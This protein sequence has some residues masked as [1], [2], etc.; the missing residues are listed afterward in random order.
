MGAATFAEDVLDFLVLVEE[1]DFAAIVFFVFFFAIFGDFFV[2]LAGD[3]FRGAVDFFAEAFLLVFFE[4]DLEGFFAPDF[5]D[6]FAIAL[7]YS[8]GRLWEA[9]AG[10]DSF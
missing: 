2:A 9:E 10:K 5:L 3:F 7:V 6:F 1:T 8:K 4:A